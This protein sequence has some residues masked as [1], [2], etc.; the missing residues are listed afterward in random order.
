MVAL[1]D[2]RDPSGTTTGTPGQPYNRSEWLPIWADAD[3]DCQNTRHEVL[4]IEVDGPPSRRCPLVLW[5]LQG[6]C[7]TGF[8]SPLC[9]R[10]KTPSGRHAETFRPY[11][12]EQPT[13]LPTATPSR[14]HR[15]G[16]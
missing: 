15:E 6:G 16:D 12:V 2:C 3:S 7:P 10:A 9:A 13:V 1:T 11:E 8:L 5:S 4:I 14:H